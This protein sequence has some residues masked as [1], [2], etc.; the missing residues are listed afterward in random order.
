M[1]LYQL[2]TFVKVADEGN[3]TRASEAL[4][5]SQPAISGQIKALEEALGI[6][7]FVR[8][9]KGM[10][11]TPAG[12]KLYQQARVTLDAADQIK[13][14]AQ[15]LQ[16]EL[17]G[18]L[19]IGMHTD[20]DYLRLGELYRLISQQYPALVS[21]FLQSSSATV[22]RELRDDQLDAGFMFGPCRADDMT[23]FHLAQVPMRVVGPGDWADRIRGR[24]LSELAR[25]PWVYTTPSCPF[26]LLF[27]QLFDTGEQP[28]TEIVWCD[29]EDAIRALIRS[30]V[31]LSLVKAADAD[32]ACK[33]GYGV[34]WE[35]QVPDV[36][37]N[38]VL[39]KQRRDEPAL[40]ALIDATL[41]LWEVNRASEAV[42]HS[43]PA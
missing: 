32:R 37:L 39:R 33:E 28:P 15:S 8:N 17:I 2:K 6:Q 25:L 41:G 18:E 9:S 36:S 38:L 12:R 10:L 34:V 29:N 26:F 20:Y 11:L 22:L 14:Q 1:E 3:L 13:R 42:V 5:T 16:N 24:S 35:G 27:E 19:R 4:Y 30:G 21:H 43:L 23:Q 7:L 40:A 31:G